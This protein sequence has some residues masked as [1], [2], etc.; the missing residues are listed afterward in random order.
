MTI[1]MEDLVMALGLI[2]RVT[3]ATEDIECPNCGHKTLHFDFREQV[4]ACPVC[5]GVGGGVMDA[6]AFFRGIEAP[7]KKEARKA[8]KKDLET[9]F[10]NNPKPK[11]KKKVNYVRS[12][13]IASLDERDEFYRKILSKLT[14]SEEH[15]ENLRKRGL[16]DKQIDE[17]MIKSYRRI[18]S[19]ELQEMFPDMDLSKYPGFYMRN[20]KPYMTPL[21]PGMLINEMTMDGKIQGFQ[22]RRD[23]DGSKCRYITFSSDKQGGAAG[24]TFT[25]FCNAYNKPLTEVILTEGPLKGAIINYLNGIP[26]VA[27]PG[28]NSQKYLT[29]VLKELKKRGLKKVIIAFDMD[30]YTNKNVQGALNNLKKKLSDLEIQFVQYKWNPEFKGYDDYLAHKASL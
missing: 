8:A 10:G 1:T 27:I 18:S 7:T 22:E 20:N 28:V 5:S 9:Y 19:R 17:T 13:D 11:Q 3:K 2:P 23:A 24:K 26:T 15:R 16:N 30:Y 21:G 14:L 29:P 25:H 12:S 6:W 4:F